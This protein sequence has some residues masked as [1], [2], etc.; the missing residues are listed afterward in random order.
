M[1]K[2]IKFGIAIGVLALVSVAVSVSF[3]LASQKALRGISQL[4]KR[5]VSTVLQKTESTNEISNAISQSRV[6]FALDDGVIQ[7]YAEK[8]PIE[9]PPFFKKSKENDAILAMMKTWEVGSNSDGDKIVLVA[10]DDPNSGPGG[11][12]H[13]LFL[14]SVYNQGTTTQYQPY[15]RYSSWKFSDSFP[16]IVDGNLVF[17]DRSE[18]INSLE[19]PGYIS[20]HGAI[21]G[22]QGMSR[23]SSPDDL[24]FDPKTDKRNLTLAYT[25]PIFGPA[26]LN[27]PSSSAETISFRSPYGTEVQYALV[28]DFLKNDIPQ[29]LWNDGWKSEDTFR[30]IYP[31]GGCGSFGPVADDAVTM[32]DL[33]LTG[34]TK[35][36]EPIYEYKDKNTQYLKDWYKENVDAASNFGD[37][38]VFQKNT[39]YDDFVSGKHLVF[40]WSDP[41]GNLMKF[42]NDSYVIA[43]GC[44]KPVIY[45]YPRKTENVSVRVEPNDGIT[46]SDPSY[47]SGWNVVAHPSGQLTNDS[48][49]KQYPYL[50]WEGNAHSPYSSDESGFVVEKANLESFFDGVLVKLGLSMREASDFKAFWV[51]R[52]LSE[53]RSYYFVTFLPKEVIDEMAP[54]HIVPQPESVVRIFM[55]WRGL[56]EKISVKPLEIHT[57]E[58]NGF[59]VVEWGGSLK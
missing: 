1:S 21:F 41:L 50:F 28:P 47:G 52:M 29:I 57:P 40:F 23:A 15:T 4:Q 16:D 20:F 55:R 5:S 54:L 8:K 26:F 37:S 43:G 30:Q 3:F 24:F 19:Y 44:G 14:K 56:D 25:D 42:V 58:R 10:F 18:R 39:T 51:S 59:T 2:Q 46:F 9:T 53:D 34:K 27:I 35:N 36:G 6:G 48:D 22:F 7:W 33:V 12:D 38:N 49:G 17:S 32:D 11:I 13:F 45:L 31:G